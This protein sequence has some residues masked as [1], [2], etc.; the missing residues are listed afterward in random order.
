MPGFQV[1]PETRAN[2]SRLVAAG[3]Q[4]DAIKLVRD[5]TRLSL[6][7]AKEYVD[8]LLLEALARTI[9]P[10][11]D[12]HARRLVAGGRRGEAVK[13]LRAGGGLGRAHA[14]Q[15]VEAVR[16]GWDP[17]GGAPVPPGPAY[18]AGAV[19]PAGT[20]VPSL[21]KGRAPLSERVRAFEMAGDHASAVALVQA[22]TGM[23]RDEAERFVA[24]LD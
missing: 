9:P 21:Q 19:P 6:K 23:S 10:D 18:P 2:A 22:E 1:G 17:R 24:A 4:I 20:G 3:R 16:A 7:D 13:T 14:K 5:A 15:Y 8:G 12:E 11:V